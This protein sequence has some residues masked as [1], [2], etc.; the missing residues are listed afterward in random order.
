M[1][2]VDRSE[3]ISVIMPAYNSE[4]TLESAAVSVLEQTYENIERLIVDDHSTD[5][6]PE[7]CRA[8]TSSDN[9][10]RVISNTDNLGAL[11]SRLKAVKEAKGDWI[12]FLD[13]DDLWNP[14]KLSK[15]LVVREDTGC[16]LVY[17][18]S[19]FMDENGQPYEWIM[20]V[21]AGI[22]YKKL[23]KQNIISNSSVLVNK[24]AFIRFAPDEGDN[25]VM[26]E[27]FACCCDGRFQIGHHAG[28]RTIG[29]KCS[30]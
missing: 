21:P 26:H 8:L 30:N 25:R 22:D 2:I 17:T 9:R 6:T 15:Q 1:T 5:D 13:S 16:D 29:K 20:H 19:A 27:D 28:R 10:V 23:L 24:D 7:I 3:L 4:R 12:A 11:R 14:D 18:G